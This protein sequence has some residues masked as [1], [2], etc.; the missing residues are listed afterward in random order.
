MLCSFCRCLSWTFIQREMEGQHA[1]SSLLLFY[2]L[3]GNNSRHYK[4][5]VILV[6][7]QFVSTRMVLKFVECFSGPKPLHLLYSVLVA[8]SS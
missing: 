1:S 4:G 3:K 5:A 8:T 2:A 7:H 6:Q